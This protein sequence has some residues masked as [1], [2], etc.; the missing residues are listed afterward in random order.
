MYLNPF[1]INMLK[2][3]YETHALQMVYMYILIIFLIHILLLE[4]T[5]VDAMKYEI[6][7][8]GGSL[9]LLFFISMAHRAVIDN[10]CIKSLKVYNL[11]YH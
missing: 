9:L 1:G 10:N 3:V 4:F 8:M 11:K 5:F 2:Y 6:F 7:E